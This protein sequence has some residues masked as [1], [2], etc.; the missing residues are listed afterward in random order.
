MAAVVEEEWESRWE[1]VWRAVDFED[2]D[3]NLRMRR[4]E[5][6]ESL[7]T[8][9]SDERK[10]WIRLLLVAATAVI[11]LDLRRTVFVYSGRGNSVALAIALDD[12]IKFRFSRGVPLK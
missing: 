2:D 3:T 8:A 6:V 4:S 5:S 10:R 7:E 11:G 1:R 12:E 9:S